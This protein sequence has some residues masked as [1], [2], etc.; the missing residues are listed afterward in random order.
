MIE[1]KIK[2]LIE[3][4]T[5]ALGTYGNKGVNVTPVG[6]CKVIDNQIIITDNFMGS[7]SEN[8]KQNPLIAIA[9]WDDSVSGKEYGY[10]LYGQANYH[11]NGKWLDIV[12]KLPANQ[13]Y[14][15]KGAIVFKPEKIVKI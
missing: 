3:S 4:K 14:P 1:D 6:D 15:A 8:I 2:K 13:G 7:T 5:V 9:V 11:H 10:K 12:K